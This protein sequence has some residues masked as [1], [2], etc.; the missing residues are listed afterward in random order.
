MMDADLIAELSDLYAWDA[1]AGGG[2]GWQTSEQGVR[3]EELADALTKGEVWVAYQ[4]I[5]S[6][7][8]EGV[9][10]V[11]VLAR[12]EHPHRGDLSPAEFVPLA[13]APG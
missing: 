8:N 4:P 9:V 12:W 1:E 11:E 5:V 6:L 13:S 3:P 7:A 2:G 10:G